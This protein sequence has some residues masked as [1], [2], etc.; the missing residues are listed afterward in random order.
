MCYY[1]PSKKNSSLHAGVRKEVITIDKFRN[2]GM[3]R[4][5]LLFG[6]YRIEEQIGRGG[7]S[8]V[9]RCRHVTLKLLVA[10]KQIEISNLTQSVI[11]NES[12]IL[13]I[14]KHPGIPTLYDIQKDEKYYYLIEEFFEG[15]VLSKYVQEQKLDMDKIGKIIISIINIL[16]YLHGLPTPIFYLDL[17]PNNIII[18]NEQA[19]L[20]DFGNAVKRGEQRTQSF[21][22]GTPGYAAPEQYY[23][24]AEERSD[25]YG[26]GAVLYFLL[27]RKAPGETEPPEERELPPAVKELIQLSMRHRKEERYRTMEELKQAAG[28]LIKTQT[29]SNR[30][31]LLTFAFA[32]SIRRIGTTHISLAFAE[33]LGRQGFRVL[34]EEENGFGAVQRIADAYQL[35]SKCGVYQ[36]PHF[37]AFPYY[38][39]MVQEPEEDYDVKIKDFGVL[40]EEKIEK[41]EKNNGCFLVLGV[42][43]WEQEEPELFTK[44]ETWILL[45]NFAGSE[46]Y[47]CFLSRKKEK[48]C[49]RV[50]MFLD[51]QKPDE[52]AEKFFAQ[53][54]RIFWKDGN[55]KGRWCFWERKTGAQKKRG[56]P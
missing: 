10:V 43:P 22:H 54:C 37:Q 46:D 18:Q 1:F 12:E 32:G 20:V 23:G 25:I 6:K 34:Y 49:F 2:T 31:S 36:F 53:L 40:T 21:F 33:Y 42:K 5:Q 45:Y 41:Y 52:A 8:R 30:D 9:Y 38:N 24:G 17:Q 55:R 47:R 3:V 4:G 19:V 13:K 26:V 14:L 27:Y 11:Q 29:S 48:N 51:Y 56:K 50:P 44:A 39:D 35:S 28:C 15:E 16:S 7:F